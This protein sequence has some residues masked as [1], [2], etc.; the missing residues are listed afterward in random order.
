M[1]LASGFEGAE[2]GGGG[3]VFGEFVGGSE[4]LG[5]VHFFWGYSRYEENRI[6]ILRRKGVLCDAKCV[7][8]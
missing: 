6:E 2:S 4:G 3:V 5:V 8:L 7:N 1:G